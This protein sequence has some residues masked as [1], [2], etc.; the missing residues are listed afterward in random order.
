MVDEANSLGGGRALLVKTDV[1]DWN[2]VEAMVKKTLE[3]FGQIDILVNNVGGT[4]PDGPFM[5]KPREEWEKEINLDFWSGI[6]CSRGVAEGIIQQA[7]NGTPVIG[8]CGGDVDYRRG[9]AEG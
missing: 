4:S 2:S 5:N 6:N 3:E 7:R 9:G 1:S 8:I